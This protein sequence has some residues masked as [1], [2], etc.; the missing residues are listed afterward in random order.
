[1]KPF[2]ACF[3]EKGEALA[4]ELGGNTEFSG[5]DMDDAS[6][7]RAALDGLQSVTHSSRAPFII[8]VTILRVVLL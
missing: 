8:E 7:L 1:M 6:A 3:R 5:F 4:R 2:L